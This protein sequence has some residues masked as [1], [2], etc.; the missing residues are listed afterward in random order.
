MEYELYHFGIKGMKWG[1]RR[2]QNRDGTLTPQGKNR[3]QKDVKRMS[4]RELRRAINRLEMERK[5]TRL[6]NSDINRG[7]KYIDA[8]AKTGLTVAAATT[9]FIK[10]YENSDKIKKII[11]KTLP[12][13]KQLITKIKK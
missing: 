3:Y 4:D 2:F 10:I 9:T 11:N 6:A 8:V 13:A 1:I 7:K 12:T 5:Y